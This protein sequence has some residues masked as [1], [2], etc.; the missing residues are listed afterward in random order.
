[1]VDGKYKLPYFLFIAGTSAAVSTITIFIPGLLAKSV[2]AAV[3]KPPTQK[4]ASILRSFTALTDSATLKR[5]RFTSLFGSK[6][7]ASKRRKAITSVALPGEP[8]LT[9]FPLRSCMVLMPVDS[10]VATCIW[11][12]YRI[13]KVRKSIGLPLNLSSPEIAS[14]AAS[15]IE[16]PT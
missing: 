15:A 5:S 2:T 14:F 11:F 9:R 10:T 1:M 12:G 16:K 4:N 7:A 6:P 8:V 3:G 13:N